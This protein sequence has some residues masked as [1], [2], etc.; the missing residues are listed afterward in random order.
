M[1]H[2]KLYRPKNH[3]STKRLGFDFWHIAFTFELYLSFFMKKYVF[4][5]FNKIKNDTHKKSLSLTNKIIAFEC[6]FVLD[7]V[8]H[9][10]TGI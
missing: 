8:L 10:L 2:P 7:A 4:F 6:G 3:F 9:K 5:I 1:S